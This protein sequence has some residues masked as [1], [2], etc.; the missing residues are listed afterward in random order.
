MT[1]KGST[2]FTVLDVPWSFTLGTNTHICIF[3]SYPYREVNLLYLLGHNKVKTV[4]ARVSLGIKWEKGYD[5]TD[6]TLGES[7][8]E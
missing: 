6:D 4:I 7:V 1:L 8:N 2:N 3:P 5:K